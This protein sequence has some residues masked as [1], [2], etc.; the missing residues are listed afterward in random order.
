MG[1][2]VNIYV[3]EQ[4]CD[5]TLEW[6]LDESKLRDRNKKNIMERI[7]VMNKKDWHDWWVKDRERR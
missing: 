4:I 6:E 5:K 1:D 7:G 3:L 2:Y